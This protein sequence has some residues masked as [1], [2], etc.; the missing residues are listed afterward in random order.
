MEVSDDEA[1]EA[2]WKERPAVANPP[3]AMASRTV[4]A[5]AAT[6]ARGRSLREAMARGTAVATWKRSWKT[7]VTGG[8]ETE[9]DG[10]AGERA[11]GR[12]LGRG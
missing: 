9:G 11:G 10:Q 12:H 3:T 1:D 7:G 8:D 2:A 5:K 6:E 4:E